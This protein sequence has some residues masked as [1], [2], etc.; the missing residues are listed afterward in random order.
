MTSPPPSDGPP[1]EEP[2]PASPSRP[3]ATELWAAEPEFLLRRLSTT[4]DGLGAAEARDRLE[5]YGP[6]LPRR[7]V[8]LGDMGLLLAQFR[9]PIILL[10]I[11]AAI[12]SMSLGDASDAG[13]I[14]GIVLFSGGLGFWQERGAK[15]ALD[16]LLRRVRVEAT[17]LRDGAPVRVPVPEVMPGDVAVLSAGSSVP[18]DCRIL[19]SREL[20][21]DEAALTGESYPVEKRPGTLPPET[22][23]ARRNN[24]LH[25]GTHV[26]S[27]T[28]R[29]LVVRTGRDTELGAISEHLRTQRPQT[30]FARGVRHF[31]YFLLELTLLLVIVIFALNVYLQRP[32]LDSFLFALALA[33]GLTPQLLPA[34]ISVNLAHGAR[35]MAA[36]KVIVKRLDSIE[37]FGSMN[38]LCSDKTGT[39][40][41]GRV[42]VHDAL[43]PRGR[44]SERVLRYARLNAALQSAFPNPIDL[45]IR[46]DASVDPDARKVDEL[47]YD[48]TRKRISVLVDAGGERLLLTK[49][50]LPQ[51]LEICRTA[52][53]DGA[54]VAL[55]AVRGDIDRIYRDESQK[56]LRVLGVAYRPMP[57]VNALAKDAEAEMTFAGLLLLEDPLKPDAAEVVR[58]LRSLGVALKVITG[59]NALAAANLAARIGLGES[60]VLR[61]DEVR[62]LT[63][64]A[65]IRRVGEVDVFAE[66]EPAQKERILRALR[67]AGNVVGYLGDGINDGPALHVADVGISVDTAADVA[68]DT[69]DIVLLERDLGVL[70]GGVREGRATFANTLKYVFMATSANFGNMF[71]MAGASLL[72]P[73]LPLLPKQI[74]LTNLLTDFPEMAIASD[75]V[76]PELVASPRRWN[77]PFI[78]RFMLVF[79]LVSSIFDF[80]TFA[81]LL[82]LMRATPQQF[83]TGWFVESV[84]SATLVVLVIRTRR[85][86]YRARPSAAMATAIVIVAA[87]ALALPYLPPAHALGF[88]PLPP[89]FLLLLAAIVVLYLASAEVTKRLFFGRMQPGM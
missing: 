45:A 85:P 57:G 70:A 82:W 49:G 17:V 35:R 29:A 30:E 44:S 5:R 87:L 14:I 53:G 60:R 58:E 52:D 32:V 6:N 9:S 63:G 78:R 34:I 56:G 43:D 59:D 36:R 88:V 40:T 89:E 64:P 19:Q 38:V 10:L 24:L 50:A 22:P 42:R 84:V 55:A 83:R 68:R 62:R 72:L 47:P 76:D 54:T 75:R 27:G 2:D 80:L 20:F 86:L 23:L 15:G 39:L 4:P 41:E 81:A 48:F 31:G 8:R 7:A 66:V 61:G 65:L 33:V 3:D 71:S 73:F 16:E 1:A 21:V 37:N 74:L 13:I 46:A 28:A 12:L 25:L 51:V 77:L 79:G 67:F 18:G 26:M 69:A 11:A